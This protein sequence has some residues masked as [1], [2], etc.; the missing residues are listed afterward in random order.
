MQV[1]HAAQA[2]LGASEG[3]HGAV[4][5]LALTAL[6]GG[7]ASRLE[8]A[9]GGGDSGDEGAALAAAE[10]AAAALVP[11]SCPSAPFRRLAPLLQVQADPYCATTCLDTNPAHG[12]RLFK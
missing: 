8:A 5:L 1:A 9:A 10:A 6:A 7:V 3:P 4:A 2:L 12:D 11:P